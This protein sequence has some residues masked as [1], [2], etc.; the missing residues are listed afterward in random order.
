MESVENSKK[1]LELLKKQNAQLKEKAASLPKQYNE[2][3][4]FDC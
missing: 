4:Y 3:S 2:E 1:E